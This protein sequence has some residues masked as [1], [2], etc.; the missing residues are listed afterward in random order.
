MIEN[1]IEE[2]N[3]KE[4]IVILGYGKEGK[5]TYHFIRK[6][7]KEK[8]LTIAD[9]N[10]NL[11]NENP[12]L[13]KDKFL[14]LIL[15]ND[16]LNNLDQYDLIIK[17]PGVNFKNIDY[18]SFQKKITS[19]IDLFLKYSTYLTIGITGTKG[20][21]TTTSL[22]YHV[23]KGME[24]K[25]VLVGNIGTPVFDK[26]YDL[27]KDAIV[28]I[29]LGCHQLQFVN[30]SPKISILLNIFQEHLDHYKTYE[31]YQLAKLNIFKYQKETD[32]NIWGIDSKDSKKYLI[33]NNHTYVF[34]KDEKESYQ[35][36]IIKE[37][38][39]YLQKNKKQSII[40]SNQRKRNLLGNHN[41]YNIAAVFCVA[42]ILKLNMEKVADLIDNFKP[43]EH[44]LELV[45]TYHGIIFYNDSIA[46]IPEATINCINSIPKLQTIIL[47]GLKRDI[48]L[49][50]LINF[51]NKNNHLKTLIFLKDTG[52]EI[53]EE[54]QKLNCQKNLLKVKNMKE[55]VEKAYLFTEKGY[56]CALSPAAASYN[57]YKNF[58]ER[59]NDYKQEVKNQAK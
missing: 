47:G 36:I 35:G 24:K 50:P 5:S 8:N 32:Y 51:L 58:E 45:G 56:A 26:I 22:I 40:Y 12:E 18:T 43:L 28:V 9:E 55:A 14:N 49:N 19:Q 21:S 15:G 34:S 53:C 39:L 46:T 23:L 2:I 52:Y 25:C 54:L 44:R 31:E 27:E 3:N 20:K 10:N 59:G 16:Y 38:G 6:Y 4:K 7:L 13:E 37:N 48:D 17:S 57:S 30:A 33:P 41:L 1:I 11:K 29:E 42:D